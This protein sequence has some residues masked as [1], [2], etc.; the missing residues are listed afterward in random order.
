MRSEASG[1]WA[2][3][4]GVAS[5]DPFPEATVLDP[6]GLPSVQAACKGYPAP[7]GPTRSYVLRALCFPHRWLSLWAPVSK[8]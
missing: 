2:A 1:A 4:P 7:R 6:L 5:P 3:P 8:C